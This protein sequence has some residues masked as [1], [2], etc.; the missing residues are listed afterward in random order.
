MHINKKHL[1]EKRGCGKLS[2]A[3]VFAVFIYNVLA[4]C[5]VGRCTGLHG[6]IQ[7]VNSS[8]CLGEKYQRNM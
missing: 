2:C 3:T 1:E 7:S 6:Y 4:L 5:G 8:T